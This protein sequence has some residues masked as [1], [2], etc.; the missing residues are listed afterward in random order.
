MI[1]VT[2]YVEIFQGTHAVENAKPRYLSFKSP[3][4]SDPYQPRTRHVQT[5][6]GLQCSKTRSTR[7][8]HRAQTERADSTDFSHQHFLKP[9][10]MLT[11]LSEVMAAGQDKTVKSKNQMPPLPTTEACRTG[12]TTT[13][14]PQSMSMC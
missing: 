9:S 8:S 13:K 5:A 1:W 12:P 7:E 4:S 10:Q 6:R 3:S 11:S 2:P 14:K